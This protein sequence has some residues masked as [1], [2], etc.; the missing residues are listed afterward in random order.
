SGSW[1]ARRCRQ[2][3]CCR[4]WVPV[5]AC[6]TTSPFGYVERI[7]HVVHRVVGAD[8]VIDANEEHVGF[9]RPGAYGDVEHVNA[10]LTLGERLLDQ[11]GDVG[12]RSGVVGRKNEIVNSAAESGQH[13]ALT[14]RGA[15]DDP[16]G[17]LHALLSFGPGD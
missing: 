15:E 10:G 2:T 14:H 7:D 16:D 13:L 17:L 11:V 6:L 4:E 3:A 1:P 12:L 9:V 5:A 8:A